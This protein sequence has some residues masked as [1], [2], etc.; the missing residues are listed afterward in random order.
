[1]IA[2]CWRSIPGYSKMGAYNY[3]NAS[4]GTYVYTGFRPA[5]VIVKNSDN[6]EQWYIFDNARMD[7]TGGSLALL[8]FSSATESTATSACGGTTIQFTATG[9]KFRDSNP[10]GGELTYGTRRYLFAAFAAD[11]W[12][13]SNAV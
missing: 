11:A 5:V 7:G 9:F 1:M 13:Y 6:V 2:Y 10:A 12:E 8:R 3:N 4:D